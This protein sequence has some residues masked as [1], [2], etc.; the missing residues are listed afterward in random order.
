[1]IA[2]I[3]YGRTKAS[4]AKAYLEYLFQSGI[5]P[6]R[7]TTGNRGAWV[8]R[9]VEA[10]VQFGLSEAKARFCPPVRLVGWI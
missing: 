6:Y 10:D 3:W 4:D 1:M 8:L 9:R 5:P 7:A 2:R